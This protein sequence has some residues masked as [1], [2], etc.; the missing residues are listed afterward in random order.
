MKCYDKYISRDIVEAIHAESM[1]VLETVGIKIENSQAL[2]ILKK[3][4]A[5]VEG[6]IVF[7]N[8]KMVDEAVLSS[9][10]AFE[11]YSSKGNLQVGGGSRITMP[12][13][14]SIYIED[15]GNIRKMTNQDVLNVFKLSTTSK[16]IGYQFINFFP[17]MQHFTKEQKIFS[18]EAVLLKYSHQAGH[19]CPN[20]FAAELDEVQEITR[21]SVDLIRKF[22]GVEDRYLNLMGV[23]SLSPLCYDRSTIDKL[24]VFCE[25]NQP[26]WM[27]PCGMPALTTPPSLLST[28]AL[29]NAEVVAGLVLAQMIR[30]GVPVVYGNTSGST[31]LRTV[32]LSIGAPETALMA[33]A[34]VAMA[35]YYKIPCRTGGCLSDAKDVDYQSGAESMLVMNATLE[36]GADLILHACG[37]MGSFNVTSLEKFLLDEEAISYSRRMLAGFDAA[38]EKAFLKEIQKSGP[39][40]NYMSG[41][42]PKSY[43]DEFILPKYFNKQDPNEWQ[44]NGS[45]SLKTSVKA[46]V[47]ERLNS[48]TAPQITKEQNDLIKDYLPAEFRD[49]IE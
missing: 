38:P 26:V 37:I 8:Q 10:S 16:E 17:D 39:R 9:P 14:S 15:D 4:G 49:S 47:S 23:N 43:R 30:P 1:A 48:Y 40:G 3:H 41:R 7:M 27:T 42:T 34:S 13:A 11:M 20:I 35:D 29:T 25:E 32:Q 46:A 22:E 31:N 5:R 6:D 44:N 33:Y 21:K 45:V 24:I 19:I 12:A 36:A 2:E 28:M 18:Q